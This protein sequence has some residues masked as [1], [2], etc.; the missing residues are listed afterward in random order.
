MASEAA[1]LT[2]PDLTAGVPAADIAE[3][4]T[5]LG[6]ADGEAVVLARSGGR[7]YA[8]GATCTHYGGPLAEGLVEGGTI[9]CPWHHAAFDLA[10]GHNDRPPA[11][12]R[13]PCWRVE[14]R[15][16][17]ARVVGRREEPAPTAR[18]STT[19]RSVVVIGGGAAG[20]VAV[21]TLRAEGYAGPVTLVS[22]EAGVPVDRP[23]LSK[24]YLAGNAPEEWIPLRPE[25]WYAEHDVTLR[26]GRRA[27]AL[28]TGARR[29]QLDDGTSLEYG[30]LLLA[31]G[32]DPVRLPLGDGAPVHYLRTLADSRAII[33][34]AG[35][36]RRA[37]VLGASFI[38]LEVAASLRTRGLD[39]TVVAPESQPLER[40]LGA[41]LGRMVREL[42][43]ERGVR[44]RLGR[45]GKSASTDGLLLD[46]GELVPADFVVAGVGVRPNVAL[47]EAA[48][49]AMDRGVTVSER[50]ETSAP[51][52]YAAGDIARWPDPYTGQRIRVEHWVVA[53]RQ[54]RTAARNIL[55]ADERFAAVPFFWSAHYDVTI[56]YVGHAER[57]DRIE[58]EGDPRQRDCTVRY[59]EGGRVAAVATVGRDSASLAAEAAMEHELRGAGGGRAA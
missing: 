13:L 19:P 7:L 5:L 51:G 53:Q 21:A 30:A 9:R 56:N 1:P 47:A 50:L 52:V 42:H 39:V 49:L 2:G 36:A 11:L 33:A 8:V 40:V 3:G 54:A 20:A 23:N 25:E 28:D 46:D 55:G 26:L 15:G 29:V 32:A 45:T 18:P 43:E 27:T 14:E 16:D 41:E 38:G 12:H 44:F 34:A 6:H 22:A 59:H 37:V 4:A 35:Q 17:V 10:T 58:V 57:P 24:D 48:G 31:T